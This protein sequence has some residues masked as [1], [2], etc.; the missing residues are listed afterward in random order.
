M[1]LD[2]ILDD[3]DITKIPSKKNSD[4]IKERA[5]AGDIKPWLAYTANVPKD[6]REKLV[7]LFQIPC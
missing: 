4:V 1:D 2:D 5:L 3:I 7:V 6:T